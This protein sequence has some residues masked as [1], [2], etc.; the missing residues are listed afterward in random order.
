MKTIASLFISLSLFFLSC[1]NVENTINDNTI[2]QIP[3][4]I[5]TKNTVE[6]NHLQELYTDSINNLTIGDCFVLKS[7]NLNKGF[8]LSRLRKDL[9]DFT[10]VK[11]DSLKTGVN[12]FSNGNIR[13]VP[14][15]TL[16]DEFN[17]WGTACLSLMGQDDVKDFL[18]SFKK[19]GHLKFK[20]KAPAVSS[21]AYLYE[22][23]A[24][25]LN[26][27]F[28]E[29]EMMW[30]DQNKTIRLDSFIVKKIR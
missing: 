9:Y 8:I 20:N 16:T 10:P 23:S 3:S 21:S 28:N 2:K 30:I 18:D 6:E 17:D 13:M 25:K 11:L 19:I 14:F 1:N 29:Q 5:G 15:A 22:Y 24:V 4:A 12:K 7:E 26:E 27:F